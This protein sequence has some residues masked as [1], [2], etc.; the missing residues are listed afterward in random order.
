MKNKNDKNEAAAIN[1]L[2]CELKE[3]LGSFLN[4]GL[5]TSG[6]ISYPI[7]KKV[8][9][10]LVKRLISLFSFVRSK[11]QNNGLNFSN[12]LE[13]FN[14]SPNLS[15][16]RN[17]AILVSALYDYFDKNKNKKMDNIKKINVKS[18]ILDENDYPDK[19]LSPVL[20]LKKFSQKKLYEYVV[21]VHVHGSLATLDYVKGWSDFDTLVVIKKDTI[22]DYTK[23][24]KLRN[25]MY[26]SRRYLYKI[27]PLQHHGHLIFT[28]YDFDYYCQT[29]FPIVLFK[30][31][32]SLLNNKKFEFKLRNCD[33]ENF[34]KFN[35]FVDYFKNVGENEKCHM[36]SYNLKFFLHAITLFPTM[37]LQAKGFHVYKKFS[38]D[39]AKKDFSKKEWDAIDYVS[40]LRK[41]WKSPKNLSLII[42]YA[43]VNPLLAYQVNSKYWDAMHNIIKLNKMDMKKLVNGMKILVDSASDKIQKY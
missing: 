12:S 24:L 25:L 30:Y 8:S 6:Y 5:A 4:G 10:S 7:I 18:N 42:P 17:F 14:Q 38:F 11:S 31:S 29:F 20:E 40:S 15:N 9:S 22:T 21:D 41:S 43:K 28:E 35:W 3:I 13:K 39:I 1:Y 19:Y 26:V 36:N 37:Y 23:I 27:D 34:K 2:Q 16:A 32:K 33:E